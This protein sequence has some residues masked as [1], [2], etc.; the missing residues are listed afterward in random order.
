M[1]LITPDAL[2]SRGYMEAP[3]MAALERRRF[4]RVVTGRGGHRYTLIFRE[5]EI[6]GNIRYDAE[7]NGGTSTGGS[8]AI[9][10]CEPSIE[11]TEGRA[12]AL[13]RASGRVYDRA[14]L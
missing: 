9:S 10:L 7:I 2:L 12:H 8:L 13:W 1:T 6:G 14:E 3:G 5:W 11:A 4:Q